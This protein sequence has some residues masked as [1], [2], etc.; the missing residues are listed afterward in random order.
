MLLRQTGKSWFQVEPKSE[1]DH[2][3]VRELGKC[4]RDVRFI[5]KK[6]GKNSADRRAW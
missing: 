4:F 6:D 1:E 2:V 3:Q 5:V